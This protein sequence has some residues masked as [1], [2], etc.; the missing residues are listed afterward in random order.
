MVMLFV[1]ESLIAAVQTQRW[2]TTRDRFNELE[3]LFDQARLFK[4]FT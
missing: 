3:G 1:V 2:E 4:K